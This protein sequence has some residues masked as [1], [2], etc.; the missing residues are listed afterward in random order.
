M[1]VV[2]RAI[3][4]FPVLPALYLAEPFFR[5]RLGTMY[6][7]RLGHLALNLETFLRKIKDKGAPPRTFYLFFG[8]D[9]ANRQLFEMWKRTRKYPVRVIDSRW[10]TRM[11][12]AWRPI[13]KRTRFWEGMRATF[14][15]YGLFNRTG[16]ILT[17]TEEEERKG[18]EGL[19]AMGIGPG[20]WF[21]LFFARDN[22]F[23]KTWRP[24]LEE[25]WAKRDFRDA[26]IM[27]YMKAADYIASLGGFALRF[28]A[29]VEKPLPDTGNSRIIDYSTHFRTDFMDV[30][31][32]AKCRF[33]I[34]SASGPDALANIF[35][36]PVVS[37]NHFPY[38]HAQYDRRSVIVPR[39]L[40]TP[41]G[42]RRV[43]FCEAH[44]AGYFVGWKEATSTH[45]TMHLFDMLQTEPDDIVDGVKDII[46]GLEGRESPSEAREVQE[47]YANQ[48]L[49]HGREYADGGNIGPRFAMK[50]RD[51]I[52]P[53][54]EDKMPSKAIGSSGAWS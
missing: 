47:L 45:K 24:E 4:L 26:D 34:G 48:F 10:G 49:S 5:I 7:Q 30:Y 28:G 36:R 8:Y 14:M 50:Y 29:V 18:R 13:L 31:L 9:P 23:L 40:T 35:N 2:L 3:L 39:P 51:L 38:N 53:D 20:D 27:G 19:A 42:T 22:A 15:E 1:R 11:L 46:D 25:R 37:A 6:T 43:S 21:V 41:D 32:G 54:T 17:F 44:Q 33:F 12:F 16:P 52:V